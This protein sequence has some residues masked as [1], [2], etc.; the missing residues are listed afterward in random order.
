M[1]TGILQLAAD[2]LDDIE[3][4]RKAASNRVGALTRTGA[5]EDGEIRGLGLDAR[6]DDVARAMAV[7]D[8]IAVLENQ[9]VLN[10][11]RIMRK[12]PLGPFAAAIPGV[13]E[14]QVARLIAAVGDPYWADRTHKTAEGKIISIDSSPRTKRE[15]FAY[16]G[17][18]IAPGGAEARRPTK[19]MSQ[20]ELKAL[21]RPEIK[22]R[23]WNIVGAIIK[24]Q[25]GKNLGKG[26]Y[27]VLYYAEKERLDGA[28]HTVECKRCGPSG[29]PAAVGTLLSAGHIDARARRLIMKTLLGDM[30]DA[31][32]AWHQAQ[33]TAAAEAIAA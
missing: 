2:T 8:S 5:D 26:H 25:G 14:K 1:D 31:A 6:N 12:H 27:G 15:L 11:K 18:G 30:Y 13:G 29:K 4:L 33:G 23:A 17:L 32:E 16:A 20:V 7:L 24:A 22:M 28:V 9:Q 21:G 3:H 10:L 19:G